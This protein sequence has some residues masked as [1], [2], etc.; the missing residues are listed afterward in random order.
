MK[1]K[2]HNFILAVLISQPLVF[3]MAFISMVELLK[4][5][6]A[7]VYSIILSAVT[8]VFTPVMVV[9][10]LFK[11]EEFDNSLINILSFFSKPLE[12]YYNRRY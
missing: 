8:L 12:D 7:I 10:Y 4:S 11:L 1:N 6:L 2:K 5:L 3:L 9:T